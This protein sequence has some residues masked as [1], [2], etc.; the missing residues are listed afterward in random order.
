MIHSTSSPIALRTCFN[1]LGVGL[2][3]IPGTCEERDHDES[4]RGMGQKT[5]EG[6]LVFIA[7]VIRLRKLA[8]C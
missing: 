8:Q 4:R 2:M 7:V 6:V 3:D 5:I 1:G